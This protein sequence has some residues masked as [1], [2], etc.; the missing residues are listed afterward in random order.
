MVL[1]GATRDVAELRAMGFPVFS[2]AVV[3]RGPHKGFG[4]TIDGPI[5]AGGVPVRPGDLVIGDDDG[6]VV[7][8]LDQARQVLVAAQANVEK[9]SRWMAEIANGRATTEMLG[10]P[11]PEVIER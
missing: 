10:I 9:E 4:G 11:E 3:P 8:P 5:A 6:V 2:R 7:V 1:D